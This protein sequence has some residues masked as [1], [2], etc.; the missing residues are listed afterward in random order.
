MLIHEALRPFLVVADGDV[1]FGLV[2]QRGDARARLALAR[3][4]HHQHPV[5]LARTIEHD[6]QLADPAQCD[7]HSVERTT[8]A[9][10]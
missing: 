5:H 1:S 2:E 7:Q 3:L 6:F 8:P 9:A 10:A 4:V